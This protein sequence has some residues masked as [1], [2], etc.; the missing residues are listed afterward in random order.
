MC[1]SL[2]GYSILPMT[3]KSAHP[4]SLFIEKETEAQRYKRTCA[5][6]LS[7]EATDHKIHYRSAWRPSPPPA[8]HPAVE[9]VPPNVAE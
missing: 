1:H 2:P 9:S 7:E 4:Y 3:L 8:R 5:R 6:T